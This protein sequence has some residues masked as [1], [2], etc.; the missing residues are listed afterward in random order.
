MLMEKTVGGDFP[1]PRGD[2]GFMSHLP[3]LFSS[4][5]VVESKVSIFSLHH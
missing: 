4:T 5:H 3:L 1:N 2:L